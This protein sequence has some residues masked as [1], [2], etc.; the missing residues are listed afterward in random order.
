MIGGWVALRIDESCE[1][2]QLFPMSEEYLNRTLPQS[3]EPGLVLVL[4]PSMG[5]N[6]SA[7]EILLQLDWR[8]SLACQ[9]DGGLPFLM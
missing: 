9:I 4:V 1:A 2:L 6:L 8:V 7:M 5:L 3:S